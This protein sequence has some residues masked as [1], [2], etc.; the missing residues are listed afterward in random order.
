MKIK[1]DPQHETDGLPAKPGEGVLLGR[2]F[3]ELRRRLE[4]ICGP[5]ANLILGSYFSYAASPEIFQKLNLFPG[6]FLHGSANS[7]KSTLAELM[8]EIWGMS[9][10]SGGCQPIILRGNNSTPTGILQAA[11]QYSGLPIWLDEFRA[12][13]VGDDK[14]AVI[15]NL[16][17]R[18]GQ[19]KFSVSKLQRSIRTNAIISGESTSNDSALRSRYPHIQIAKAMRSGT[20]E[21]QDEN[22]AW[23]V[24]HRKYFRFFGLW[25][26]EQREAFVKVLFEE[27]DQ[28]CQQDMDPR[29]RT[30]HGIGYAAWRAVGRLLSEHY[31]VV[32]AEESTIFKQFL[33]EHANQAMTDVQNDTNTMVFFTDLLAAVKSGAIPPECFRLEWDYYEG[34]PG[35]VPDANGFFVQGRWKSYRIYLEPNLLL[36]ELQ[37]EM[38]KQRGN[39]SL[40]R[41]DLRDQFSKEE[42]WLEKKGQKLRKRFSTGNSGGI[43]AWGIAVDKHPMGYIR[44]TDEEYGYYQENRAQG[45]PRKGALFELVEWIESK[46]EDAPDAE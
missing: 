28:W 32:T 34:P 19:A 24:E 11:D 20:K 23:F 12:A 22:Y 42:W 44:I 37:K 9:S 33:I 3:R 14:R 27:L 18:G 39:V 15:H 21:E 26:L 43:A 17:N 13:E 5:S 30:V 6:L 38:V 29:L 41:N 46:Q 16:Y 10:V 45:D 8:M 31:P 1:F 40:K 2:F 7:G 25:L 35:T 36:A 4:A